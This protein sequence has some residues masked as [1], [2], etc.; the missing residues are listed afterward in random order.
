MEAYDSKIYKLAKCISLSKY[1]GENPAEA[2]YTNDFGSMVKLILE[3][4]DID[5]THCFGYTSLSHLSCVPFD[6]HE[7]VDPNVAAVLMQWLIK[8]GCNVNL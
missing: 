5:S 2:A 1:D 6:N 3:G 4:A 8:K 7:G